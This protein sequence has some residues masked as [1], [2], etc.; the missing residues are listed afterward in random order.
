MTHIGSDRTKFSSLGFVLHY[1]KLWTIIKTMFFNIKK[2]NY[3]RDS[4]MFLYITFCL[5]AAVMVNADQHETEQFKVI[6]G[7]EEHVHTGSMVCFLCLQGYLFI[8]RAHLNAASHM[9][10]KVVLMK[11]GK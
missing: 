9:L 1:H 2:I 6:P 10:L 7:G 3:L 11:N 8:L 4:G 5:F